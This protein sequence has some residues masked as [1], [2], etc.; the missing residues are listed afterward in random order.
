MTDEQTRKIVR[1]L[2]R[3]IADVIKEAGPNGIPSGHLYAAVCG[4]LSLGTYQAII[5]KLKVLYLVRESNNV[6]TWIAPNEPRR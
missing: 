5:A 3:V 2:I 6:L 4:R 1:D